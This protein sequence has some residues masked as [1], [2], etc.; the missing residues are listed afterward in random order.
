MNDLEKRLEN[1]K[2]NEIC[3][4]FGLSRSKR[5]KEMQDFGNDEGCIKYKES[6]CYSCNGHNEECKNYY[7]NKSSYNPKKKLI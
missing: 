2:Q 4:N 1:F 6:G 3:L 7:S 5:L